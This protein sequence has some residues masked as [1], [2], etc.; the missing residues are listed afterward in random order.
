M[1]KLIF[2][3]RDHDWSQVTQVYHVKDSMFLN[4]PATVQRENVQSTLK[5]NNCNMRGNYRMSIRESW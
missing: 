1:Q 3:I 2:N 4:V 5:N